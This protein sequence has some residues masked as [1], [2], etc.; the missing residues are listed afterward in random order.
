MTRG[1]QR[2]RGNHLPSR[3]ASMCKRPGVGRNLGVMRVERD[4][5]AEW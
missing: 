3:E 2:G 4:E 5:A 1:K